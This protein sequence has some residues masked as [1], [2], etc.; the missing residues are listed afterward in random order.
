MSERGV[1]CQREEFESGDLFLHALLGLAAHG[2]SVERWV[3][4]AVSGSTVD[5]PLDDTGQRLLDALLGC[6]A[7]HRRLR[8]ELFPDAGQDRARILATEPA[9]WTRSVMR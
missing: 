7:V 3:D 2:R 8:T 4:A 1:L 6:V 9:E 5:S